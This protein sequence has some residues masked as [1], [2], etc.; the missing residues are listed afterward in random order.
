[1]MLIAEY[2]KVFSRTGTPLPFLVA[3]TDWTLALP[4]QG[5]GSSFWP[6]G[7]WR[8]ISRR[9]LRIKKA[10]GV[11]AYSHG[12]RAL[13]GNFPGFGESLDILSSP[14]QSFS[15]ALQ[16]KGIETVKKYTDG[17]L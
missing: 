10:L 2:M 5:H 6:T 17:N 14:Q 9:I 4:P 11:L 8:H 12:N 3:V 1:V 13:L 7:T 15:H 16:Q